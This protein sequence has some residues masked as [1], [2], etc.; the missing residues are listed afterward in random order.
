MRILLR[1]H[2]YLITFI[3]SKI[4]VAM[5]VSVGDTLHEHRSVAAHASSTTPWAT[6]LA[7]VRTNH[8]HCH[9]RD[10]QQKLH[11]SSHTTNMSFYHIKVK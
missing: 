2:T 10:M 4:V 3:K 11:A 1:I 5:S 8:H 9:P 6:L 7:L